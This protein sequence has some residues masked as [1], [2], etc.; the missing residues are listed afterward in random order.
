[1]EKNYSNLIESTMRELLERT[2]PISMTIKTIGNLIIVVISVCHFR[3]LR[4]ENEK[5]RGKKVGWG[6]VNPEHVVLVEKVV[7]P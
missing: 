1:M 6:A 2:L 5:L 7:F 4:Q 3:E